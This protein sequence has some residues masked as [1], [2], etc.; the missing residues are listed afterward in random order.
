MQRTEK[1]T[2][3][4]YQELKSKILNNELSPGTYLDETDLSRSF[5][6]SRTPVREALLCL[7]ADGLVTLLPTRGCAVTEVS[8]DTILEI[9]Q[10]R[11][12][13]APRLLRPCF[14]HYDPEIL[15]SFRNEMKEALESGNTAALPRINYRFHK[16]LCTGS[17][18]SHTSYLLSY[19]CDQSQRIL[20]CPEYLRL[21]LSNGVSD[22]LKLIDAL[23]S[24]NYDEAVR[25]LEDHTRPAEEY[26]RTLEL[27]KIS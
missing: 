19:V 18:T 9:L 16:Y 27:L 20:T 13:I 6:V 23:L 14:D 4:I 1:L 3:Y 26:Y 21:N 11:K 24:K 5:Q 17:R 10:I 12:V 15:R 2:H 7:H 8:A 22:H 25:I